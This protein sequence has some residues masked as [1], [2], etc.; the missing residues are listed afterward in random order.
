MA[1]LSSYAFL[2]HLHLKNILLKMQDPLR[3]STPATVYISSYTGIFFRQ[4][5]HFTS[6]RKHPCRK[7]LKFPARS[8]LAY[9]HKNLSEQILEC[10]TMPGTIRTNAPLHRWASFYNFVTI[11]VLF[12]AIIIRYAYYLSHDERRED[13]F[14]GL[15]Q[16]VETPL[17]FRGG[18]EHEEAV[19]STC[20]LSFGG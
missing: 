18:Y 10:K 3:G 12:V 20:S 9:C 13:G 8:L 14:S 7:M 4:G 2:N 16:K 19:G 11:A 17:Q 5:N 1:L 6:V 15:K